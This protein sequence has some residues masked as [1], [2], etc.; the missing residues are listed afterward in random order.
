MGC[1]SSGSSNEVSHSSPVIP[2]IP[3][4]TFWQWTN[5]SNITWKINFPGS[6]FRGR[7]GGGGW[8]F[9]IS[10]V[11]FPSWTLPCS[12]LNFFSRSWDKVKLNEYLTWIWQRTK[13]FL[14]QPFRQFIKNN[15][16]SQKIIY[17]HIKPPSPPFF[18]LSTTGMIKLTK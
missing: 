13:S 2:L 15:E 4:S 9:T 10:T 17:A 1:T 7:A 14:C 3:P 18:L 8:T 11:M 16:Q 12:D 6:Q 5:K